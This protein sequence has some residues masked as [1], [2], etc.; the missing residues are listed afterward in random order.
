MRWKNGR[1]KYS[2]QPHN[3]ISSQSSITKDMLQLAPLPYVHFTDATTR[4]IKPQQWYNKHCHHVDNIIDILLEAFH[5]F[6]ETHPIYQVQF[7]ELHFRQVMVK[8]LYNT[9]F[10][11]FKNFP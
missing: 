11:A 2:Y 1:I 6:L 4:K 5:A 8:S 10:S 3:I 9:S 7:N